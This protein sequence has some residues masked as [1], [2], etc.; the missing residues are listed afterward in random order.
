[1]S[2]HTILFTRAYDSD[3][4]NDLTL[5]PKL[6]G[7]ALRA[8]GTDRILLSHSEILSKYADTT[9]FDQDM[10]CDYRNNTLVVPSLDDIDQVASITYYSDVTVD[11]GPTRVLK[12]SES[13]QWSDKPSWKRDEAPELFDLE[14]SVTLPA[15]SILLYT[16]KTYH[17]GSA[18]TAAAGARYSH[19]IA[20]Q[21][22]TNTWAGWRSFPALGGQPI[23]E[24][25]LVALSADQ[26]SMVGFPVPGDPYWTAGTIAAVQERYP[27]MDM[28]AYQL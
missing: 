23:L 5:H 6:V 16:M 2:T 4:L 27:D 14:H 12:F 25:T 11:L 13:A 20:F 8:L 1:M 24:R 9:D 15:G 7:F 18:F 10:H 26:R 28:S 21:R 22:A 19:H 3:V 17:R